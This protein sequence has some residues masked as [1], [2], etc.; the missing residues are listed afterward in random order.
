MI[1]TQAI[2]SK[3]LDLAM[4]GQLTDQLPEDGT[5]DELYQQIQKKKQ[6]LIEAGKIKKEKPLPEIMEEEIPFKIPE[7][8]KWV[9]I[10]AAFCIKMGQSPDGTTVSNN[11]NGIEF[12]QGK[13]FFGSKYLNDSG[14]RTTQ[15]TQIGEA[16]SVL[17]CVRA[18]VGKVNITKRRICLGRGLCSISP[19]SN[20]QL[21]FLY[22]SLFTC[23]K[24]F[25]DQA[26]GSTFAAI[27]GDIVKKQIIP[28]PPFT[29][30]K[31]IVEKIEQVFSLLDTIDALQAQYA[32]NLT[33]LKTKLIDL[34]IQGKLTEQ[35]P[36]DGTAEE[37]YRQIQEEKQ[38]LIKEG[39]LKKEKPL[40]EIT[41][42]EIPFEIPENWKWVRLASICSIING[43]RGKNYP[44][45]STL[46]HEGI[47][48]ISALNLN[49]VSV[50]QDENLLCLDDRQYE[51]LSNGKLQKDDIVICIRGSLGKHGR[52]P[53]DKGAIASSLVISRLFYAQ[54]IMGD[55][56]TIWLDSSAF[57]EEIKRYNSG[58]AQPNLAANSLEKF[59]IPLPPLAEQKRIIAKLDELLPL[60]EK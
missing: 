41:D 52:Y 24:A 19:I 3:I 4:R 48:F 37:L 43:D 46:K 47:P 8:W 23:E 36:E 54:E 29:E 26:T 9:R 27:G 5:A 45:K 59:L 56:E 44:A 14:K 50:I 30:Q 12:H 53:F 60:L 35:L 57:P 22:Y 55:Y 10:G 40:P 58:T 21:D 17:L 42:D 31:R 34:A 49:G 28:L 33:A 38:K 20:T 2:R 6:K 51:L 13:I 32:D 25:V 18:P 39:K 16:N 11:G 1:D 7:N 15:P